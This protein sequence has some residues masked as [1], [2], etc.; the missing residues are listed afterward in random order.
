M[1]DYLSVPNANNNKSCF[2]IFFQNISE[3]PWVDAAE[4]AFKNPSKEVLFV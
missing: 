3:D 1:M 4:K 2:L